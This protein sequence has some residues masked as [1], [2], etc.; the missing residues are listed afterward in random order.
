LRGIGIRAV[1]AIHFI[2]ARASSFPRS[3]L[4]RVASAGRTGVNLFFALSGFLITGILQDGRDKADRAR[5]PDIRRFLRLGPLY[6][7]GLLGWFVVLP[8]DEARLVP[9]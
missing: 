2:T 9:V 6:C 3:P 1:L 4:Y 8:A 7:L 5:N